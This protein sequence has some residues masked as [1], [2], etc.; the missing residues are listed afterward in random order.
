MYGIPG[1][2]VDSVLSGKLRYFEVLLAMCRAEGSGER[3]ESPINA[4]WWLAKVIFAI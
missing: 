4:E 2:I 1:G 3:C